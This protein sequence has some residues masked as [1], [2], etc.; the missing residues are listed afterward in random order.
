MKTEMAQEMPPIPS[1]S[2]AIA[3]LYRALRELSDNFDQILQDSLSSADWDGWLECTLNASDH[4]LRTF[5]FNDIDWN[6]QTE[7]I[8]LV[9]R[10]LKIVHNFTDRVAGF[11]SGR[12]EQGRNLFR[13]VLTVCFT[14]D[15][16]LDTKPPPKYGIPTPVEVRGLAIKAAVSVLRS[17][18]GPVIAAQTRAEPSWKTLRR[19]VED[20]LLVCH[21]IME[22]SSIPAFP[23]AISPFKHPRMTSFTEPDPF[24]GTSRDPSIIGY[25]ASEAD[26]PRFLGLALEILFKAIYP[27]VLSE[28][29][30]TDFQP[31]IREVTTNALHFCLSPSHRSSLELRLRAL[32]DVLGALPF[33]S[34]PQINDS[35]SHIPD[36]LLRWRL[37]KGPSLPPQ[38][39]A[40]DDYLINYINSSYFL[41]S[42]SYFLELVR[43]L[44]TVNGQPQLNPDVPPL[45]VPDSLTVHYLCTCI[46]RF[47]VPVLQNLGST[48]KGVH[49][50]TQQRALVE[51]TIKQRLSA[52]TVSSQDQNG[53]A[54]TFWRAEL[55]DI[56][57]KLLTPEVV[58]WMDDGDDSR[59][60]QCAI[61]DIGS[62]F[63]QSLSS[64]PAE[65]RLAVIDQLQA[66]SS[67]LTRY[68]PV[69]TYS[70]STLSAC[71]AFCD[72][73]LEGSENDVTSEVRR[74]L[75]KVVAVL[76]QYHALNPSDDTLDHVIR[77]IYLGMRHKQRIVRMSAGGAFLAVAELL[78]VSEF[79]VWGNLDNLF[80]ILYGYMDANV[81]PQVQETAIITAGK[82]V[83]SQN[84]EVSSQA[85]CFL[86]AQ[87]KLTNIMLRG[88][89][90]L[91]VQNCAEA[92]GYKT[93]HPLLQPHFDKI[94]PFLVS[95]LANF[96]IL[97]YETCRLLGITRAVFVTMTMPQTLPPLFAECN[98]GVL[99]LIA[100]M[101]SLSNISQVFLKHP[102]KI[103]AHIF[104]LP[105]Q[106]QVD[107][108][109][110]FI[111]RTVQSDAQRK[112]IARLNLESLM[113]RYIVPV[114]AELIAE[115]GDT[116]RAVEKQAIAGLRRVKALLT[117]FKTQGSSQESLG[118][119]LKVYSLGL[120][121]WLSD[122]LHDLHGKK[123]VEGKRKVLRGMAQMTREI[124]PSVASIAPQIM[125]TLQ[126]MS[127]IT[128]L[129][130]ATIDSWRQFLV[131]L[132]SSEIGPH[133]GPTS[134]AFVASWPLFTPAAREIA[135]DILD[136]IVAQVDP[137]A[138]HY[139]DNLADLS[140]IP[141]LVETYRRLRELRG[142]LTPQERLSNILERAST[143]NIIMAT[144]ALHE[145]K[146]FMYEQR[147]LILEM[148]SGDMFD[149]LV[150][151]VLT[152]LLSLAS[153]DAE[154][155]EPLRLLAFECM[156]ILGA[157]DP[158]RCQMNQKDSAMIVKKNFT[159]EEES[160]TFAL[161]I[162]SDPLVDAFRSTSDIKYQSHLAFIIQELLKFCRF[163]P[164]LLGIAGHGSLPTKVRSRW[165]SLPK[166][167]TETV[168]PLLEG[169]FSFDHKKFDFP[170]SPPFYHTVSTYREWIQT[171]TTH[172]ISAAS[173]RT[174][175][176]IFGVF[177]AAVRNRDVSVAHTILPHLVLNIL[178]SGKEKDVQSIR[179]E[180]LL[181]LEDQVTPNSISTPDKRLFSAQA[182]FMLLDHLN[183]WVRK[184]RQDRKGFLR[185][186]NKRTRDLTTVFDE[187][188]L[189]VDSVLSSID[190]DLMGN[191]AL[192][193]RAYARS[194]MSFESCIRTLRDRN[195]NHKD[196][197]TYYERL[198]EVYAHLDEPD[199]MEGISTMILSP[200]LEHQIR[201]HETSGRW[202]SAQ[203]CW[204]VKLQQDPNNVD[205]HLGLL[206]CLRN[207]GHYDTLRTHVQGVLNRNP[208]WQSALADFQ[209]ESAWLAGA[210]DDVQRIT[211]NDES[212]TPSLVIARVLLAM[213]SKDAATILNTLSAARRALGAPVAVAGIRGYHRSYGDF[214]NLHL[215]HELELI[216]N[217]LHD[218]RSQS[219]SQ[220]QSLASK[221]RILSARLEATLPTFRYREAILSMRRTAFTIAEM[222]QSSRKE[223]IGRSWLASAKIARKS[224]QWQTAYSAMLQAR[225]S[226]APFSFIE[227]ARLVKA[228]GEPLRALQQL[229]NSMR[230]EGLLEDKDSQ[231]VDLTMDNDEEAIRFKAKVSSL[232]ARWMQESQRFVKGVVFKAYNYATH[233][234]AD[235][236]SGQFYIGRFQD[237]WFKDLCTN[238]RKDLATRGT[239]MALFTVRAFAR[240][241]NSGSK[242]IYQTVPRLLTLW[243]DL[244]Q[245][246]SVSK[247]ENFVK[248][249]KIVY[250]TMKSTPVWKWYI[251]FPQIVSRI[252][253]PT[254][255]VYETLSHLIVKVITEYPAQTLWLFVSTMKSQDSLR[256]KR[257]KEIT[258]KLRNHPS[259]IKTKVP[260]IVN[261]MDTFAID[262]LSLCER[263]VAD[264]VH[265][266]SMS[267]ESPRLYGLKRSD[268]IIPL[269]ES[270][271]ANLPP[272]S[273]SETSN[274]QPFPLQAPTFQ[275]FQDE[276]P[277]MSSLAKPR[278][279]SVRGSD[280]Q[281]YTFLAKPK[282]DLRKD[283]RLMDFYGIINKLLRTKSESRR[284]QLRIRTYGVVTLN[285]EC[286]LIQWVPDTRPVRPILADYYEA[287][288]IR[289][290][291]P[292]MGEATKKIKDMPTA[293]DDTKVI[294]LFIK[295]C[296]SKC[297]PVFHEWF[298]ETFP[299]SSAWLSSRLNYGRTCAVMCMVG[300][301]LGLGDRHCENMLMDENCGDLI[302][303]DFNM[304]FE[305]G[306]TLDTPERVPFRLTHNLVD[307]LGA[308]GVEGV[309]RISCELTLQLLQNNKDSLMSVLD[310]F[311]H[312]PLVEWEEEKRKL[313]NA[314]RSSK[315][316]NPYRPHGRG[317]EEKAKY[318]HEFKLQL[319]R[320]SLSAIERKLKGMYSKGSERNVVSTETWSTSNLV[321]L[322]IQEAM[323]LANLA[324]MWPGWASWQ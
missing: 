63:Q 278:K 288:Q 67:L 300:F 292:E 110:D 70:L 168:A 108:A 212:E 113:K 125:A 157:V 10:T 240:A 80:S 231:L 286:G 34:S 143:N 197:P 243:L 178:I 35:Y 258:D 30:L 179:T 202:T 298:I 138:A 94:A 322:L 154:E 310:A 64:A 224:G 145:L 132:G 188:L 32:T 299:E 191:A 29:F 204:E 171:W 190:Q 320:S 89:V 234:D 210:W 295:S 50:D 60:L 17:L 172:L 148:A 12:G 276:I 23:V 114:L 40:V 16:W 293:K 294:E 111:N 272:P 316:G 205:S 134:A 140:V 152:T 200:S 236:E 83:S 97:L 107:K 319:A 206:R 149:P 24:S 33:G 166:H 26:L 317:R 283:A 266:L 270:L 62:Q 48:I 280:G 306:K 141:E 9:V 66:L 244:G 38:W 247:T 43:M 230:V 116:D 19:V 255:E 216:C 45:K 58:D 5:T 37:L 183:K 311:I 161:H 129:S 307:G 249:N 124:G 271:I 101:V 6:S 301:I 14:L 151:Q 182:V 195:P 11:L 87:L 162:I 7:N 22:P 176:E 65:T 55:Q 76:I 315:G 277:I 100:D 282:D 211:D 146:T 82:M 105:Q 177:I 109:L 104:T 164:A 308:T 229:E 201:H 221:N 262:M 54:P 203:S 158:D 139:I 165:A 36:K 241:I 219:R 131:T 85:L 226:D 81:S 72:R 150:G 56:A 302:H 186:S 248:I 232:R 25:M 160:I 275:Q 155:A 122:V 238:E 79:T 284:R 8:D 90:Y 185:S 167:V 285:E 20:L 142:S 173:G 218:R 242:F 245:E 159:D 75:F 225:E 252:G 15:F 253:H 222:G 213:R 127:G 51:Q 31:K 256:R 92:C 228:T 39:N 68:K 103:L 196:L 251:A 281:S 250:D 313:E 321:E 128:E 235:W 126:T 273:S 4:F 84:A 118:G 93:A 27:P 304:L 41:F 223:E 88:T 239:K 268:L 156:A 135:K 194:L 95:N 274:H 119:F 192:K 246:L 296:L 2:P 71:R 59:Y 261:Q 309:F 46:T 314:E 123:S 184:I 74:R 1:S 44:P 290:W 98:E 259:L 174:A 215:T 52:I 163:T 305:R 220:R 77:P 13:M 303:V 287:R 209:V 269:Q 144:Q 233:L 153:R 264:G 175:Q 115:L 96:P 99:K 102:S 121:T 318:D 265:T 199:G 61:D 57:Q 170:P 180:M 297:P 187:Q 267:K 254:D 112:E 257:A 137:D 291:S 169:K 78:G 217:S 147:M 312:D 49:F 18:G 214:L 120:I 208:A 42:E 133:I 324:R 130:E 3:N 73:L 136:N 207:L 193:C 91:Q 323:D 279:I 227:S 106:H 86:I 289:T 181:V 69:K 198:H 237:E 53:E 263:T 189:K 47:E 21:D 28:W 260:S 117:T